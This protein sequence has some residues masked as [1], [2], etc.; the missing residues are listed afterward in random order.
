MKSFTPAELAKGVH[1]V[2]GA[3]EGLAGSAPKMP[4]KQGGVPTLLTLGSVGTAAF[5]EV[6]LKVVTGLLMAADAS[7]AVS[8]GRLNRH[9]INFNA[10]V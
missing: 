1:W 10:A 5:G 2:V 9:S 8:G 3:V 7:R 6:K 4:P